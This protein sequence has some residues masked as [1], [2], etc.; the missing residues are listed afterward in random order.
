[1]TLF[2]IPIMLLLLVRF[3]IPFLGRRDRAR[4]STV[5]MSGVFYR[6]AVPKA[7]PTITA[8]QHW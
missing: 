4:R 7:I 8:H 6:V 5:I 3:H 2:P 1:M